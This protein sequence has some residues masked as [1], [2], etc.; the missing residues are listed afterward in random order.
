MDSPFHSIIAPSRVSSASRLLTCRKPQAMLCHAHTTGARRPRRLEQLA[1][2]LDERAEACQNFSGHRVPS[3]LTGARIM[4][5][6]APC[7]PV[8]RAS[9]LHVDRIFLAS[10]TLLE[11]RVGGRS[12]ALLFLVFP[13]RFLVLYPFGWVMDI[14][15]FEFDSPGFE[16]V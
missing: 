4:A 14:L 10:T 6:M 8:G 2:C 3:P 9:E 11:Q 5:C 13:I 12:L 16:R 7:R 15:G 1:S